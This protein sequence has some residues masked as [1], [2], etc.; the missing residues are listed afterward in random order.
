M[1]DEPQWRT[2]TLLRVKRLP[3]VEP[4]G[5]TEVF[6]IDEPPRE[7]GKIRRGDL[8]LYVGKHNAWTHMVIVN[9][10]IGQ[11]FTQSVMFTQQL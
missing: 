2:G 6:S 1:S 11:V 9:G 5:C 3:N 4:L 7:V 10:I 8:V